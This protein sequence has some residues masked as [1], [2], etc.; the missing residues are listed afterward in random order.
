MPIEYEEVTAKD[1]IDSL[2]MGLANQIESLLKGKDGMTGYVTL[3]SV[4]GRQM[5]LQSDNEGVDPE[6]DEAM[7]ALL[8]DLIATAFNA[9][10]IILQKRA[11][12]QPN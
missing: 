2:D 4:L 7:L 3:T 10:K 8:Y 12:G 5:A 1:L 6:G 9:S 11:H